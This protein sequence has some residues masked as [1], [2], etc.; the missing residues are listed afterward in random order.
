MAQHTQQH[1]VNWFEIPVLEQHRAQAFY[2]RLLD[3]KLDWQTMGGQSLAVI[4]YDDGAV[5]GCLVAAGQGMAPSTEGTLVYLNAKPSLDAALA[6]V[7]PAGGRITTPK[8]QLPG[9]LGFFAHVTDTE[10]NRIGLH[11]LS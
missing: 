11:A 7:E 2:E 9:D 10:G 6:R 1:A 3:V 5:G 8:V 4:P